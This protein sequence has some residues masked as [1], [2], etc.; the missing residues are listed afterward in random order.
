MCGRFSQ[1]INFGDLV[2]NFRILGPPSAISPRNNIAPSQEV[3]AVRMVQGDPRLV[4]LRWGLIPPWADDPK[5]G[6][7][8]INA[9]GETVHKLPS[10][11]AAY[12]ERRCNIPAGGFFE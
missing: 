8:M 12:H 3:A 1:N 2:D 7:K 11:R 9:R 10:F 5:I 6:N 4:L